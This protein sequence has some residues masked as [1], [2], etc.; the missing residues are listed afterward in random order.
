MARR[1]RCGPDPV[2]LQKTRVKPTA[3]RLQVPN[4][5]DAANGKSGPRTNERRIGLIKRFPRDGTCLRRVNAI[6]ACGQE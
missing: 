6:A 3:D 2:E 1:A 5:R 4:R